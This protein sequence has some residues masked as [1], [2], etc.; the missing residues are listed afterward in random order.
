VFD[1][2]EGELIS[3]SP[4]R[5]I[6]RVGGVG[7]RL[8]APLGTAERL[9]QERGA[10]APVR[11]YTLTV[12]QEDL[13]RLLGFANE[14]ERELCRLLLKVAGIGPSLALALLSADS[15]RRLLSA[16][17]GEDVVWLKRVKGVGAKTAQR[18]CLEIKD[19]ARSWL[20]TLGGTSEPTPRDPLSHDAVLA[21]TSLGFAPTEAETRVDAAR[22][23]QPDADAE[24]LVKAA[25][26]GA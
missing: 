1:F 18:I 22:R 6:L 9:R 17:E 13:P 4:L 15:P 3:G 26:R 23:A 12:A 20:E 2:L 25:L 19:K 14:E 5:L 7:Y 8:Q 16:I 10:D 24:S 11:V 21:L